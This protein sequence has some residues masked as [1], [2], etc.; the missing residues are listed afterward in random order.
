MGNSGSNKS[1]EVTPEPEKDEKQTEKPKEES[2]KEGGANEAVEVNEPVIERKQVIQICA[3]LLDIENHFFVWITDW[4]VE[5]NNKGTNCV[6]T[7][8]AARQKWNLS[9]N[10]L[11]RM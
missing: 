10:F 1:V 4:N 8:N 2:A 11:K 6:S 7:R 5:V 3:V 9:A